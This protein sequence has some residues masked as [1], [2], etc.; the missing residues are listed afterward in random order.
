MAMLSQSL[1]VE[2]LGCPA[3]V[4]RGVQPPR[5]QT[6]WKAV[7]AGFV[8]GAAMVA[9]TAAVAQRNE[10]RA[11]MPATDQQAAAVHWQAYVQSQ[12]PREIPR[13]WRYEIKGVDTSGMFRKQR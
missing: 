10:A 3:G 11:P 2:F 1:P 5:P 8:A 12:T 6:S 9:L 4:C 7:T 13:E